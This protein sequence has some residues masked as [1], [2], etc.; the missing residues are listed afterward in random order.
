MKVK[1][2]IKM[3]HAAMRFLETAFRPDI[4]IDILSEEV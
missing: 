1:E 3:I 4:M 2:V